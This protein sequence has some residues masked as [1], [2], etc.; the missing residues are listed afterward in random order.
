MD[1]V[2]L[3][4][5]HRVCPAPLGTFGREE[6]Q[7]MTG[8]PCAKDCPNRSA[9]PN[10]HSTCERYL[11]YDAERKAL[12]EKRYTESV[13]MDALIRNAEKAR[14]RYYKRKRYK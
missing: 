12:A 2:R 10:C 6:Q 3:P 14:K 9:I 5:V 13:A 8:G 11:A 4:D 7:A 1:L